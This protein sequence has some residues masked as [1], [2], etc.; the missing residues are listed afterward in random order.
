MGFALADKVIYP[1]HHQYKIS[2]Y[3]KL[4]TI[5]KSSDYL[6]TTEKD[7]AKINPDILQIKNLAVLEID[8]VI[9]NTELFLRI[10]LGQ[11]MD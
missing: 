10:L 2:D 4:R 7:I 11:E 6:I 9:D 3:K 1:D 5:S 8:E